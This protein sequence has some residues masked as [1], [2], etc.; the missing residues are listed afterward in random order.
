MSILDTLTRQL[1]KFVK[2]GSFTLKSGITSHIYIDMKEII[3]YPNILTDIS[4]LLGKTISHECTVIGVPLGGVP[5]ACCISHIYNLS[6]LL[7]REKKKDHGLKHLIEGN[8]FGNDLVVIEDVITTGDSLLN[9]L[10]ILEREG[11]RI[12][13]V[14]VIL[15]RQQGGMEKIR[16]LGYE[17]T[18]LITLDDLLRLEIPGHQQLTIKNHTLETLLM[19]IRRKR[20]N[21]VVSLDITNPREIVHV[22]RTIR[23][24]ICAV[25]LHLD[26]ID[27]PVDYCLK[28]FFDDLHCI[29]E[30]EFMII[31]DRKYADIPYISLKQLDLVQKYVDIVTLHSITGS[32]LLREFDKR[33]VGLLV[34][35]Q[36]STENNLIDRV[37]STKT[38]EMAFTCK[39]L[40]GF[41][42]QEKVSEKHLTFSPGISLSQKTDDQGQ[43]YQ[44]ASDKGNQTD[45]FIVGRGI[46]Q[47]DD[48]LEATVKYQRECWSYFRY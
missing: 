21:L 3:S 45:V 2:T 10:K 32:D 38:R 22:L 6:M 4:Y 39:N 26:I 28:S 46:Y 30:N 34:V 25:K 42:S 17:I 36:L 31:E 20:S 27:F 44:I 9:T 43:T 23:S 14:L 37:Y 12:R 33:D 41:I 13:Q 16:S 1:K 47:S 8:D 18:S 5:F 40:V 35:D 15:D 24:H 29:K 11:K 19:Y 48:V 7:L